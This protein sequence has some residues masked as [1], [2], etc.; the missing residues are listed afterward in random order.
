[1]TLATK[2][3]S[4]IYSALI[5]SL[6]FTIKWLRTKR[7]IHMIDIETSKKQ[8]FHNSLEIVPNLSIVI[9][10]FE[11]RFFDYTLPL[12][13]KIRSVTS[14]PVIVVINGSFKGGINENKLRL[15]I[16]E[17][18]KFSGIYPTTL[19]N[20]HG[21]AELWNIG[22][23][24]SDT[25]Y[26]LILNDDIHIFPEIFKDFLAY[27]SSALDKHQLVTINRS[28]S[29]FCISRKCISDVG[30]FDEHF[31]G[32]GDEDRD[33]FF[34][35]ETT[36]G[37]KPFNI[38]TDAFFNFSDPSRDENVKP[39]SAGKYSAFNAKIKEDF[40]VSDPKGLVAG[41]YDSPMKRIKTFIDPRPIWKFR[42]ENY[43][44]LS[45]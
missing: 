9:T 6:L 12:I 8:T 21:C 42:T 1:M 16:S 14:N 5:D 33:Y 23:T 27:V 26:F 43:R 17:L 31:L 2:V 28:F 35:F 11:V 18:G 34:R 30:F 13:S 29:H 20:F 39:S 10:T 24:N 32:I 41:R 15:F 19:L 4:K 37:R 40:Y 3:R 45:E 38:R 44:K 7:S 22:I 25:E 36:Y